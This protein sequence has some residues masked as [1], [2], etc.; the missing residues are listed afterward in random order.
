MKRRGVWI[1][2]GLVALAAVAG[3]VAY[4]VW[5]RT[6]PAPD[7]ASEYDL[8]S[9]PPEDIAPGTVVG[10]TAPAGWSHLVI[11]S[12]PRV[13]PDHRA[14]LNPLTIDKAAWMFTAFTADVRPEQVAGRTRYRFRAIGLGLGSRA[15]DGRDVVVT[16]DT[17]AEYGV[18]LD[19]ITREILTRGYATQ[20]K[21][22]V[23]VHGPSFA[24]L[25]TPVWARWDGK[26]RLVRYRYPLLVDAA[27]GRLD[28]LVWMLGPEGGLA[29]NPEMGWL[30]PDTIDEAELIPDME[31]IPGGLMPRSDAAFAVDHLPPTRERFPLPPELRGLAAQTRFTPEEVH[32]LEAALRKLIAR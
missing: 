9:V 19:F 12:L 20:H 6:T 4:T 11:K 2:G 22:V 8:A 31:E 15:A 23:V 30:N 27:T 25:D 10:T 32:A 24:L 18:S 3:W 21:A 1:V 26:N 13:H 29:E 16:P 7:W 28:T 17:A 14:R 5:P